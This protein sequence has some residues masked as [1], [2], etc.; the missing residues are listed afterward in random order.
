MDIG[1][2]ERLYQ[3]IKLY[4]DEWIISESNIPYIQQ[5]YPPIFNDLLCLSMNGKGLDVNLLEKNALTLS[6]I[7]KLRDRFSGFKFAIFAS[8]VP[9]FRKPDYLGPEKGFKFDDFIFGFVLYDMVS[10]KILSL[11]IDPCT[12]TPFTELG[13]IDRTS[14]SSY[15]RTLLDSFTVIPPFFHCCCPLPIVSQDYAP[16]PWLAYVLLNERFNERI[17]KLCGEDELSLGEFFTFGVAPDLIDRVSSFS[18]N[19]EKQSALVY[20]VFKKNDERLAYE[21]RF[22]YHKLAEFHLDFEVHA[23]DKSKKAKKLLGHEEIDLA[24]VDRIDPILLI[25]MLF[26]GMH[27]PYFDKIV[28]R[29]IVGLGDVL[30]NNPILK[31]FLDYR[32]KTEDNVKFLKDHH[33][34]IETL[35]N[36]ENIDAESS[37]TKMLEAR[38][39]ITKEN[40]KWYRTSY[41]EYVYNWLKREKL[42]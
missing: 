1:I 24:E 28:D 35:V 16:I 17:R 18:Y 6:G 20:L 37:I 8:F 31:D 15:G 29:H 2:N 19:K 12:Q 41:G 38:K 13:K 32:K 7:S 40:E 21:L 10:R 26:T 3:K 22:D 33:K 23:V 4:I 9:L 36:I 42:A 34:A 25:S 11:S 27:D 39:L 30:K 5:R 14:V